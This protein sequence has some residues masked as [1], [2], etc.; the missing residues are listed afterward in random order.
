MRFVL[1]LLLFMCVCLLVR[2]FWLFCLHLAVVL[3][4]L[5]GR[6]T[7]IIC[8]LFVLFF[9]SSDFSFKFFLF[10]FAKPQ[11]ADNT[12]DITSKLDKRVF[13]LVSLIF[14][15]KNMQSTLA[16]LEIDLEK[17]PLGKLSKKTIE[18]GF[19]V[20]GLIAC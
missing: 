5:F 15:I 12:N 18:Q 1:L 2:S 20:R 8:S 11:L 10:R 16:E 3:V 19:S 4:I 6:Q 14:D 9:V 17:M 7:L 13:D